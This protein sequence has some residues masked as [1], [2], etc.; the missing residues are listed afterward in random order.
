MVQT[1]LF[2][3]ARVDSKCGGPGV[4]VALGTAVAVGAALGSTSGV[5]LGSGVGV[6]LASG[7]A[8]ALPVAVGVGLGPTSARN[9]AT[10]VAVLF[11]VNALFA[12]DPPLEPVA[13]PW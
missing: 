12:G 2:I 5:L 10:V 4:G 8:V 6:L 3:L 13:T 11:K 9:A 1:P 7:V